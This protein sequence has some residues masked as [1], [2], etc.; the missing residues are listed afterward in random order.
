LK[1][2]YHQKKKKSEKE[3]KIRPGIVEH[4]LLITR[5]WGD[6]FSTTS[7]PGVPGNHVIMKRCA[8]PPS[9]GCP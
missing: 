4:H 2:Q 8:V 6:T 1:P 3:R 7:A 9:K 5:L